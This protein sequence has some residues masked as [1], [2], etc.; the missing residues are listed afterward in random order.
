MVRPDCWFWEPGSKRSKQ[1]PANHPLRRVF[2]S[3]TDRA[4]DQT[5]LCDGALLSY[6]SDLLTDFAHTEQL[7][8]LRDKSGRPV[9][10]LIDMFEE[11]D[12]GSPR[13]RK[14]RYQYIGYIGDYSLFILGMFPES[15]GQGRVCIPNSHYSDTGRRS[16]LV[17]SEL[18]SAREQTVVFRKL[19]DKFEHCVV[20]L[21][22]VREYTQEPFYQY[23]LR[24]FGVT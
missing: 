8:Q 10:C 7:Y 13:A 24:Q 11:A 23:M 17:A 6:L 1:D 12:G 18:E 4:F 3:L 14:A 19:S 15:L 5:R 2:R 21:H 22:W 20:S 9:K 16:Y